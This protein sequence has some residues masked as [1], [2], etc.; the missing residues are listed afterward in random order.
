ALDQRLQMISVS[1][2]DDVNL[3]GMLRRMRRAFDAEQVTRR[4]YTEFIDK[5]RALSAAIEGIEEQGDRDWY[6]ALTM[7]R[8]MFIYFLQRKGFMDNDPNYLRTRL[9][10]LQVRSEE[11]GSFHNFYRDFLVP[12][13]HQGLGEK[14][15][16]FADPETKTQI[17]DVRY[18]NGGIFSHHEL[19][20]AHDIAIEDG[21]FESIFNLFDGYQWHLDDRDGGNPNEI[22]PDVL[23]YI[24]EQFIN[25]KQ[26]G[27]YYTKEDVTHFMTSSTLLP[28][29]LSRLEAIGIEVWSL[30]SADPGR[31]LWD[32]LSY[33]IATPFPE[34][35]E[36]E[37]VSSVRPD[38]LDAPPE[39]IAHPGESWW[40]VDFR[41]KEYQR[42]V[43]RLT[44]GEID[45]VDE[46]VTENLDLET[47]A[48]DVIDSIVDPDAVFAAWKVLTEL[49]IVDPTCG[50][51]AFLFAALK[52][53]LPLYSAVLDA[54][55]A[56]DSS[57]HAGL[58]ALLEDIAK[59]PNPDYFLLKHA[60]LSN[61]YGVDI[62]KEAVEVARL[63]LFLKLVS[64]I[65]EKAKLEPL[66]DLDF[67]I[68]PGNIL[69]GALHAGEIEQASDDL[70]SGLT[71]SRVV[72]S[73]RRISSAFAELRDAQERDD[74][75]RVR[76]LRRDLL[77]LLD[78]V[79]DDV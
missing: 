27:A 44:A 52:V 34:D 59:H 56:V 6:A 19:E 15:P 64:A 43:A 74:D 73:A 62:M 25:Q 76:A 42:L 54:A 53:L 70:F 67:N 48:V 2:N 12:L 58:T 7:N 9:E 47:L 10:R 72:E 13:F 1:F 5:Q 39:D 55:V 14:E 17:G 23:G 31:Y 22:N 49:R 38:W 20:I 40:D 11:R 63:R 28:V 3:I 65:D 35:I 24:F 18:I 79:R 57:A 50:S 51:G 77:G 69:V 60:S 75:V 30:L 45:A 68:K 46:A 21:V 8:L 32:G 4:F 16:T 41:R 78:E 66:P 37:R 33:G 36:A 29:V 61:L 71:A 26:M